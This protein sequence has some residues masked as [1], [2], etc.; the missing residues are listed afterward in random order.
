MATALR[1]VDEEGADALSMRTLAQRLDSG[2]AT[3]Y[4]HFSNRASLVAHVVDHVFGEVEFDADDLAVTGWRQACQ[5]AAQGMF[6]ALRRHRNV[7]SLLVER[8]PAGPNAMALRERYLAVLLDNGFPAKLA[9]HAYATVARYVLGF[10]IQLGGAGG[11]QSF[12]DFPDVDP[13]SYSATAA[14]AEWLPVSLEDEFA[15][16][17]RLI[18]SGLD[19]LR[20]NQSTQQGPE[21]SG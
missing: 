15:F 17:L 21:S 12:E 4:R 9:A 2:T 18:V 5:A 6:D 20:M 1:I 10:A 13:A 19:N 3:L 7:A 16:G 14:V 8:L 11:A